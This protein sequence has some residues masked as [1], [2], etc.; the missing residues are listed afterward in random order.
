MKKKLTA[1]ALVAVLTLSMSFTALAAG[2]ARSSSTGGHSS[3]NKGS[4]GGG[5]SSDES[6][7]SSSST[8]S[9]SVSP[10]QETTVAKAVPGGKVAAKTVKV[11]MADA[12]GKVSATTLDKV[13]SSTQ[14]VIVSSAISEQQAAVTVQAIMTTPPT[15]FFVQTVEALAAM[16]GTSMVVNN[17]GTI[18]TKAVATDINGKHIASAGVIKNV[19]SG[20]LIMLMSVDEDGT[21]EYVEGVVD[22]VTGAVLGAFEGIPVVITV[23]VLA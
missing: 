15:E 1:I 4:G 12:D 9:T 20:S 23:L 16:K 22:P 18:K 13:I 7:S 3:S 8:A 2:A 11:A 5:G 21:V 14:S 6:S 19:T 10:N 17:C